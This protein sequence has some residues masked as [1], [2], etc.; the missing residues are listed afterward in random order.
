MPLKA[1]LKVYSFPIVIVVRTP[2][3]ISI[4]VFYQVYSSDVTP[5]PGYASDNSLHPVSPG[6]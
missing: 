5:W 3:D 4:N 2:M 6:G 1:M